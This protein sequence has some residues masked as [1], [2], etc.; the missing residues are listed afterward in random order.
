MPMLD[1]A[2]HAPAL[3]PPRPAGAAPPAAAAPPIPAPAKPEPEPPSMDA[4]MAALKALTSAKSLEV[5]SF[6]DDATGRYVVRVADRDS[7]RVLIQTP[8]DDLLRFLASAPSLDPPP[9]LIDA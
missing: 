1:A 3:P 8:P 9:T 6:H 5:S 7:G 2:S 4:L